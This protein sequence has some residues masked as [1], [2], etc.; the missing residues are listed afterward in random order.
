M[1]M[2]GG[3]AFGDDHRSIADGLGCARIDR[4]AGVD[5]LDQDIALGAE[6]GHRSFSWQLQYCQI[7]A[8]AFELERFTRSEAGRCSSERELLLV[9]GA[10]LE[11]ATD[12]RCEAAQQADER[13][14]TLGR[15]QLLERGELLLPASDG[16][17]LHGCER[18]HWDSF[19]SIL[20]E[21]MIIIAA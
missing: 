19:S 10:D 9:G 5:T 21:A 13:R 15:P 18:E 20:D 14:R 17:Y 4:G 16:S 3:L 2:S 12:Q 11:A 7:A 6:T 8:S 1:L